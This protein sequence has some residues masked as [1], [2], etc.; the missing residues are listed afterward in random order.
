MPESQPGD[1]W[2]SAKNFLLDFARSL[3]ILNSVK[4]NVGVKPSGEGP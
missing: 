4:L 2:L 3:D 1:E